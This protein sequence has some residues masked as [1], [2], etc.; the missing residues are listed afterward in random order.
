MKVLLEALKQ[1]NNVILF[2]DEI[3]SIVGAGNTEGH[4]D[5]ANILKPALA[6]GSIK[7]IGATT[8][9]EYRK[10]FAKDEALS[11]RFE[12]INVPEPSVSETIEILEA[13]KSSYEDYHHVEASKPSIVDMVM[14]C[15]KFITGRKF[16]DKA[17]DVLDLSCAK[18]KQAN[19]QL[20][21]K[22]SSKAKK[23]SELLAAES[24]DS[25]KFN[26]E[27]NKEFDSWMEKKKEKKLKLSKDDIVSTIS[28]KSGV[29]AEI[30]KSSAS[31]D[32]ENDLNRIVFGQSE[33][34]SKASDIISAA[35]A[36]INIEDGPM[37]KFFVYGHSGSGKTYFGKAIAES[38]FR[39][40]DSVL[41]L[42][43]SEFAH[44]STVSK[45]VGASVGYIGHNDGG[46]LTNFVSLHPNSVIIFDKIEDAC[47]QIVGIISSI[48]LFGKITD[49]SNK[50]ID[51]SKTVIVITTNKASKSRASI[52]FI[53]DASQSDI[54]SDFN[55]SR[56]VDAVLE[57]VKLSE[58][59]LV[60]I[61]AKRVGESI[62]AISKTGINTL[63]D[64]SVIDYLFKKVDSDNGALDVSPIVR[65]MFDSAIGRYILK[66]NPKSVYATAF[67]DKIAFSTSEPSNFK[68]FQDVNIS[69]KKQAIP[70]K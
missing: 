34:I 29:D 21:K 51:F 12:V 9:D 14:F 50:E 56:D 58:D 25:D 30:I 31:M 54:S 43:M 53:D 13:C 48:L 44:D 10:Y 63:V 24:E 26:E 69:T 8:E 19:F 37:C 60:K 6:D 2:I 17:F 15:D 7:C 65:A 46:L 23:A 47:Q 1:Y 38:V 41:T 59:S 45:L 20:P 22:L 67:N 49:S 52:G 18:T 39:R 33:A 11:R 32:I 68:L 42:R 62:S 16:P 70:N 66:T 64:Y 40:P 27:F 36:G 57:F 5:I 61:I 3:H 35:V 4:L 55:L 28:I